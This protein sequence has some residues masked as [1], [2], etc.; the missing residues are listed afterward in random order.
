M[1][2]SRVSWIT[3][4]GGGM[5]WNVVHSHVKAPFCFYGPFC[6]RGSDPDHFKWKNDWPPAILYSCFTGIIFICLNIS[7]SN[8]IINELSLRF[9]DFQFSNEVSFITTRALII[10]DYRKNESMKIKL[11]ITVAYKQLNCGSYDEFWH[12]FI[13]MRSKY[14]CIPRLH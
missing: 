1:Q 11:I 6:S 4:C 9:Y 3:L 2:S 5:N 8:E 7:P 14:F 12:V 10:S 13:F